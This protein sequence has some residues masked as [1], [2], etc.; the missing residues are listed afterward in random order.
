MIHSNITGGVIMAVNR[1]TGFSGFDVETNVKK[2]MDAEKTKLTRLQQSKQYKVW[3]QEAYRSVIEKFSSFK[4]EYFD[5]LKSE[6][7]FRSATSFAKFTSTTTVAG[8]ANS[9]VTIS[10]GI[11]LTNFNQ[12]IE[13]VNQLA[14]KD[15]YKSETM[16][17]AAIE[18]GTLDFSAGV[19]PATFKANIVIGSTTKSVEIDMASIS[20]KDQFGEALKNQIVAQFGSSYSGVVDYSGAEI[21]LK[22][23]GNTVTML[24][25]TGSE[26]S[27]T[28]LGVSSGA[29]TASYVTK[30]ISDSSLLGV[31]TADLTAMTINGKSLTDMG[32][33]ETDTL[34]S[35]I[36]K[37]NESGVG[38]QV[39]YDSLKDTLQVNSTREGSPNNL[40]LSSTFINKMKMDSTK[41]G[42]TATHVV[43]QNAILSL[44]GV[45]ITK[46]SNSFVIDGLQIKLNAEHKAPAGAISI[47]VK[48]D[49]TKIVDQIKGFIDTYNGLIKSV[50]DQ[51]NEKVYRAYKPLTTEQKE[52]M[53]EDE[54]KAWEEKSKSGVL[55]A[56]GEIETVLDR[57]RSALM[58][59]VEGVGLTL[60]QIGIDTTASYTDRGK[61][62]IKDEMK[63]KNAIENNYTDVVN[64]FSA[65]SDKAYLDK[66]NVSERYRENGLANRLYDIIQ[67]STRIT[68]DDNG[69]K[70]LFLTYA[71]Q[72]NTTTVSQNTLSKS[73]D[74]YDKK[75][76]RLNEYLV[77]RENYYYRMFAQVETALSKMN[78]QSSMFGQS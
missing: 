32:V 49:T 78:S 35:M 66:N 6:K 10:G 21:K 52:A 16:D 73:I 18:S 8:V 40:S 48:T 23:P 43:G 30:S 50:G 12:T 65:S 19:K 41:I 38:A 14:T 57:M 60:S 5:T 62:V 17:F 51:V 37:I 47:G 54:I 55:R 45:E 4:G 7:N 72:K 70:G 74:E 77:E 34:S 76:T 39:S 9:D 33:L 25:Q 11:G 69:N 22:S 24:A 64:L 68:P 46:D 27:M 31:S 26:S 29:S 28:W 63:L 44:N 53:T 3:E 42:A 61:L 59:K 20:T 13:Y 15:T 71:G 67:D 56:R 36:K 75:I 2:L 58:E 1:L